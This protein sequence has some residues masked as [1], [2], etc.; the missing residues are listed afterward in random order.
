MTFATPALALLAAAIAVPAL[1]I[2][3]FLKL[4]RR[5]VEISSTLL[6]KKAIQDLQANAPFQR[7]RRNIL[8][9]L[10]L[11]ALALALLALAQPERTVE[12]LGVSRRV[13]LIDRSA[14]MDA[15]DA[16][17]G[18]TRLDAAKRAALA[19]VDALEPGG[20]F[21]GEA[22]QAM[23]IAFDA[24]AEIVQRFTADKAR[25]RRA[26]ESITPTDAPSSIR[27]AFQLAQA[28]RP[29]APA[30]DDEPEG[31]VGAALAFHLFTD[32][33]IED[34]EAFLPAGQDSVIYHAMGEPGARNL[35]ITALRAERAYDAP[36]NLSI[37]VA[38]Q[39]ASDTP[40][41]VDVELLIDGTPVAIRPASLPA[42]SPA[43]AGESARG[44]GPVAARPEPGRGGMVFE[45]T[46]PQGAVATVRLRGAGDTLPT[47]DQGWLVIPPASQTRVAVVTAGN[48]FLAEALAGLPLGDLEIFAPEAFGA[49]ANPFDRFDV[50][51]LDALLPPNTP[52]G[53]ALAPGRW[54]ILGA[55][56]GS[57]EGLIDAGEAGYTQFIDWRRDHP[58]LR[59]LTLDP[60][61]IG[62]ARR[63][64]V[65]E[66]SAARP[67]AET[68][69]GPAI[70][71]FI[72]PEARAFAVL[73]DIA[74]SNWPF[75][76]GFVVFLASSIDALHAR[77]GSAEALGVRTGSVLTTRLPPG[78]AEATLETPDGARSVLIPAPDGRV[79]WGPV[80]RAG[81]HAIRWSGPAGPGD[82]IEGGRASRLIAAN[83]LDP[84]ESDIAPPDAVA[85]ASRIVPASARQESAVLRLW[86]WLLLAAL[87]V[88]LLEW[89]I[90]NRKVRL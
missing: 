9:V 32:G 82:R 53:R 80:T 33:R 36:E 73:F 50:V 60:V 2:L 87:A 30:P 68:P 8:L 31:P 37:F 61:R 10:Q 70:V 49:L 19:T 23:V 54:L 26:I 72:T 76:V 1:V 48:L 13:I 20:L 22:H 75:D 14:S 51:V 66:S 77:S 15:R 6:W 11:L 71:E 89:Y 65:P 25:L 90:Y 42:S 43:G 88:M 69:G 40:A 45:L 59:G 4:R 63:I 81:L 38:L 62:N 85:L 58:V 55:V 47:D 5:S 52:A 46:L 18:M 16:P 44:A 35:A 21:A 83:L 86:R 27:E 74:E 3:Y 28:H 39:N 12:Q 56:P 67:L 64:E 24:S 78:V 17:E 7:L 79:S 57:D 84:G 34:L 29:R 41:T